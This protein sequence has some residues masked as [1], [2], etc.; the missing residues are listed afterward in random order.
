MTNEKLIELVSVDHHQ[1]K[2]NNLG[3]AL[4]TRYQGTGLM[5]GLDYAIITN[6]QVVEFSQISNIGLSRRLQQQIG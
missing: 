2:L 4:L 6:E 5:E 3:I 1:G